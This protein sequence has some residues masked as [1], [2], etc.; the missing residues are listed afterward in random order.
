MNKWLVQL[1]VEDQ[2]FITSRLILSIFSLSSSTTNAL[3]L[4][5]AFHRNEGRAAQI[6]F[7]DVKRT[8]FV[9]NGCYTQRNGESEWN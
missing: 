1:C 2:H 5:F 9:E 4:Q 8:I 7:V 6:F 3:M